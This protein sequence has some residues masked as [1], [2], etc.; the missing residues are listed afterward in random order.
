MQVVRREWMFNKMTHLIGSRNSRGQLHLYSGGS[1]SVDT[2]NRLHPARRG[3]VDVP[4]LAQV[5]VAA[6]ATADG[7][8][9]GQSGRDQACETRILDF[10]L[11]D[12][13]ACV[14]RLDVA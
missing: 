5:R 9:L 1:S 7:V 14:R 6:V 4:V 11:R 10:A 8:A 13:D 3:R 12:D 2:S